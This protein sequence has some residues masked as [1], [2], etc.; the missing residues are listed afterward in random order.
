MEYAE[1]GELFDYIIKKDHL[2][3]EETRNIFHQIIDAIDYM[4]QMGICHRDLKPENILF[5]SSH[6][7]IKIIDFGLSNLYYTNDNNEINN[8]KDNNDENN[9]EYL[10][11]DLLETPCGSPGYAPPEMVLGYSYNGLLTDLWSSGIILYAMLCGSFPFD[12]DS[13]QILYSKIIKGI[14]EFPEDIILTDE[15]KNLVKKILVVNPNHRATINEIK[16]DPWFK[17]DY[18]PIYGLFLPIQEIPID[19][20]IIKEMEKKGYKKEEIIKNI[21]N[22]RHNEITTFYYLLVKKFN[23]NGIDTINDLISPCFSKYILEQN[24]KI[25]N[26][27]NYKI[28]INLKLIFEKIKLEEAEKLIK[29][30]EKE[31]KEEKEEKEVIKEIK[32]NNDFINNNNDNLN[33]HKNKEKKK[34]KPKIKETIINK[35]ESK[36]N[37]TLEIMNTKEGTNVHKYINNF[38]HKNE[39]NSRNLNNTNIYKIKDNQIK[40]FRN[41][42]LG[43]LHKNKKYKKLKKLLDKKDISKNYLKKLKL[44]SYSLEKSTNS[45]N[46]KE[47]KTSINLKKDGIFNLSFPYNDNDISNTLIISTKR[48]KNYINQGI[49]SS[50][51]NIDRLNNEKYFSMKPNIKT[52]NKKGNIPLYQKFTLNYYENKKPNIKRKNKT[53][54]G[55]INKVVKNS[56]TSAFN[57]YYLNKNIKL[58]KKNN[59]ANNSIKNIKSKNTMIKNIS[60]QK[61][62][63]NMSYRLIQKDKNLFENNLSRILTVSEGKSNSNS[64]GKT[65][66]HINTPFSTSSRN[67]YIKNKKNKKK[68]K[69]VEILDNNNY[70]YKKIKKYNID[71][72]EKKS[73]EL[74]INSNKSNEHNNINFSININLNLNQIKNLKERER[75]TTTGTGEQNAHQKIVKSFKGIKLDLKKIN[76]NYQIFNRN[77]LTNSERMNYENLFKIKQDLMSN[78]NNKNNNYIK[79]TKSLINPINYNTCKQIKNNSLSKEEQKLKKIDDI[80]FKNKEHKQKSNIFTN[81]LTKLLPFIK[82]MNSFKAKSLKKHSPNIN[83]KT[84]TLVNNNSNSIIINKTNTNITNIPNNR[85]KVNKKIEQIKQNKKLLNYKY[86][87]NISNNSY[88]T[89]NQIIN[90][91]QLNQEKNNFKKSP[92]NMKMK[93]LNLKGIINESKNTCVYKSLTMRGEQNNNKI[94][95]SIKDELAKSGNNKNKIQYKKDNSIIHIINK[96]SPN[97]NA[98]NNDAIFEV[99]PFKIKHILLTQLPKYNININQKSSKNNYFVFH[100]LKGLVKIIIELLQIKGNE[101]IFV[102]MKCFS[103]SQKEFLFIRKQILGIINNYKNINI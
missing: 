18:K 71:N 39:D 103:G 77:S 21:K 19:N 23:R 64:K 32:T 2:S 11:N 12:D 29:Q 49:N 62:K 1:G 98:I 81:S 58:K 67:K 4:H 91:N 93:P 102:Q 65:K 44:N 85:Y 16:N 20:S 90:Y 96:V 82:N 6:K 94:L 3:E 48:E 34:S 26:L 97:K 101:R 30:L 75:N 87:K 68:I 54:K 41:I 46:K 88:I 76:N 25:K 36:N 61:E 95:T 51:T 63:G 38:S 31:I 79:I 80:F 99:T 84:I 35:N 60:I 37:I 13:E 14:F 89:E 57:V 15:A 9:Y 40:N 42:I 5:D 22:N 8:D 92:L 24:E 72:K 47:L 74:K 27:K 17:K 53:N 7:R 78:K 59:N 33:N 43:S 69:N 50:R 56:K 45:H 100:C 66:L 83:K 86:I 70:Y 52:A 10:E 28:L 55:F 73:N